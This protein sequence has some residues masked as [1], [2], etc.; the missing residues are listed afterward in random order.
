MRLYRPTPDPQETQD[1]ESRGSAPTL[2]V[3]AL[4]LKHK[5]PLDSDR[6][7]GKVGRFW[8]PFATPA[9]YPPE[10]AVAFTFANTPEFRRTSGVIFSDGRTR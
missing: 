1:V 10:V 5:S 9:F 4:Q 8:S 7:H 2:W 3:W 6:C